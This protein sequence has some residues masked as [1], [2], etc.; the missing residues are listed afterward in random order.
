MNAP[1]D[2]LAVVFADVS[3]STNLFDT[4]GDSAALG[5]VS[6]CVTL[7]TEQVHA[8]G[9][10]LIKTI[11]DEIMCTF[12]TADQAVL[13]AKM[14]QERVS[15][16][17]PGKDSTL[18]PA[19]RVG[20]QYGPVI[21]RGNDVFGDSVNVA[22]RMA[23]TAEAG[24]ILTTGDTVAALTHELRMSTRRIDHAPVRG[25]S[26]SIEI[27][28]VLWGDESEYT[29]VRPED[30]DATTARRRLRLSYRAEELVLDHT[31]GKVEVG[32]SREADLTVQDL[33]PDIQVSRTHFTVECVRGRFIL[34]DNSANGTFVLTA[35]GQRRLRRKQSMELDECGKISLGRSF[36][37]S[38]EVI[39]FVCETVGTT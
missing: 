24:E 28:E 26:V 36:D 25:K 29:Q 32:R 20:M 16:A 34:T 30:T 12:P 38:R 31:S 1:E 35:N 21:R 19:I 33:G 6:R 14:M 11:G 27:F 22:A 10:T 8:H 37:R 3:G 15:E 9:G 7:M 13:A 23:D 18:S 2:N 5:I 17:D 39:T 4:L